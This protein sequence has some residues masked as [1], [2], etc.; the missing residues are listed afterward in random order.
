MKEID[1][2]TL[3]QADF[4]PHWREGE[5]AE[6]YHSTKEAVNSSSL[7]KI[8]KSPNSFRAEFSQRFKRK[9]TDAM[10]FGTLVHTAILEGK[11]FQKRYAIMPDFG[12]QRTKINKDKKTTWLLENEGKL[13]CSQED[14]DKTLYMID[15]VLSHKD[16]VRLLKNGK[17]EISGYF[18]D[19]ETGIVQK[20]RPDFV[21]FDLDAE[22]DIKTTV[23]CTREAFTRSIWNYRYDFQR[24]MYRQ[25]IKAITGKEVNFSAF[26]A[27]EKE[28]P[29]EC[30]VYIADEGFMDRAWQ[31]YRKS[32]DL[33][34]DSIINNEWPSYQQ[35]LENISLP[36]WAF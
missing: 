26:I 6:N 25:G 20:I 3:I 21:S 18:A 28:P 15:S 23:D 16:A 17:T 2:S 8:L 13:H 24:V 9:E 35:R 34:R 5:T 4:S 1:L 11:D 19:D 32:L 29:Y 27:V 22:V 12:D 7:K 33:L 36:T 10:K 30:A 31:D 14:L